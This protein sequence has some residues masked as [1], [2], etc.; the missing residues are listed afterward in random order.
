MLRKAV[1]LICR[2]TRWK[3]PAPSAEGV[4]AF[5]L[6]NDLGFQAFSLDGRHL[7]LET[8]LFAPA[9]GSTPDA[10]RAASLLKINAARAGK[11]KSVLALAEKTGALVL[12]Q[13]IPLKDAPDELILGSLE[14]FLNDAEF[15][16][17]QISAGASARGQ[18]SPF[19]FS[20]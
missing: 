2:K 13:K 20:R 5:S 19:S 7:F 4:Y 11:Q 16:Q 10:E 1:E 6:E 17:T 14:N 18:A 8:T 9:P 3:V 15:W 12:F